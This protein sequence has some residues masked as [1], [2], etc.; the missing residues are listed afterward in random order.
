M[1]RP[2]HIRPTEVPGDLSDTHSLNAHLARY[3]EWMRTHN[4]AAASVA[5]RQAHLEQL[6][7]WLAERSLS[8]SADVTREVLERYQRWLYYY[9]KENGQPLHFHTQLYKLTSVRAFF[10]WLAQHR[11]ILYNPAGELELPR[12]ERHLP[13][14]ILSESEAERVLAQPDVKTSLGLRDRALLETLYSTGL[15]VVELC[16]LSLY[17]LDQERGILSVRQGKGKKDRNVPI[18]VRAIDWLNRYLRGARPKLLKDPND[19]T[20]FISVRGGGMTRHRITQMVSQYVRD[21]GFG[22]RGACHLFRHTMATLMLEHGADIRYI[23]AMLGHAMVS[24]TQLYTHVTVQKL[25]EVHQRTHPAG[26][27]RRSRS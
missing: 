21:A 17:D 6:V 9:R 19:T 20:L 10:K 23:Q 4:Y 22:K 8:H 2:R 25:K 5:D 26:R 11:H 13:R 15:R 24:T 14:H 1:P 3:L 16:R 12:R 27:R 18:G 7:A